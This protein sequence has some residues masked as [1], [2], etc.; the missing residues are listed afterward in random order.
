[1][2]APT[3]APPAPQ[4]LAL[5]RDGFVHLRG[6]IPS[7]TIIAVRE[8]LRELQR[9]DRPPACVRPNN[10]LVG[11]RWDEPIVGRLLGDAAF[12]GAVAE[13]CAASDLRWISGYQSI[14]H[15]R[16]A[17]LPWH[18]DWWCWD[19][20]ISAAV[21]PAQVA[22]VCFLEDVPDRGAAIRVLPGSHHTIPSGV[23][24]DDTGTTSSTV[25]GSVTVPASAGDA[26]VMDY[27]VLHG[28][29]ANQTDA[30]RSAL[31][32][33]FAPAWHRL[34]ERIQG[35]LISHQSLPS[36]GTRPAASSAVAGLL[37]HFDGPAADLPLSRQPR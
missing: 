17:P 11:L 15:A 26:V 35:H 2:T 23:R 29:T 21:E 32:M 27:R 4:P 36:P 34:P 1:M 16:T 24:F 6:A 3:S 13:A 25:A 14:R 10:L 7:P 37:P 31:I 20:P 33:N 19:D 12:V 5:I 18:Q 9:E 22:V 28:T 8:H 30:H